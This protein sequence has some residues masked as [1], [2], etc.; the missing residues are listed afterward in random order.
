[1]RTNPKNSPCTMQSILFSRVYIFRP[2]KNHT[3]VI[4]RRTSSDDASVIFTLV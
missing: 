2:G 1:M 4:G 3:R